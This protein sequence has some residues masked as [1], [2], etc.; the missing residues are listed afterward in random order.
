[1]RVIEDNTEFERLDAELDYLQKHMLIIGVIGDEYVDGVS[2]QKYAI[3]NEYGTVYI[4]A[5]SFFR[6]VTGTRR[7]ISKIEA[8]LDEQ[9]NEIIE[10]KQTGEGALKN[11]GVYTVS[12]LKE[13]LLKGNWQANSKE[14]S[15]RKGTQKPPLVDTGTLLKNIS[16]EIRRK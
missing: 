2:V 14:T 16:Y 13:S 8:R 5:R 10:G 9:I 15:E 1:M 4:P 7:G 11:V 12:L 3:Y 6:R